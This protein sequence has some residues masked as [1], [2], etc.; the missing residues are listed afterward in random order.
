MGA[1]IIGGV[2]VGLYLGFDVAETMNEIADTV[3]PAAA[4][5]P[6]YDAAYDIFDAL[7]YALEPVF[8]MIAKKEI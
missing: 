3:Q 6:I 1:A 4:H 7:Y 5:R 2:G 8:D